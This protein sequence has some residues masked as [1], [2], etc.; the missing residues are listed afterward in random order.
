MLSNYGVSIET[1]FQAA[2]VVRPGRYG[3]SR[4]HKLESAQKLYIRGEI[5]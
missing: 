1:N 4:R 5:Y 3:F 2:I